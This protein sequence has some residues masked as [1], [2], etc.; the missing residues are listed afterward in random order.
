MQ[1]LIYG[2]REFAR[3]VAELAVDCGHQVAGY[4]DDFASGTGILGTLEQVCVSHPPGRYG[5]LM[6]IG[7]QHLAARWQAWQRVRSAGYATPALIHPHAYAA[8][9]ALIAD[10]VMLMAG[11]NVDAHSRLG[12]IAVVWP[13][14][15]ISHDCVV[16]ENCF[17]SPNATLCGCVTLGAHCFVG[18]GAG[19]ADH[20]AVP[21][22]TRIKML[23]VFGR[24]A[25]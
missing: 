22:S 18:A 16:G 9:T 8:R 25:P 17:V 21:P 5:V 4:I 2:S 15:C 11:C 10:G 3:T 6:A 20:C 13:G 23:T 7:Y 12:E 14:A 1:V 19:V 24:A